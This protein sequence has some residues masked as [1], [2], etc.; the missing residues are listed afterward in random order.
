MQ[1][2]VRLKIL[3]FNLSWQHFIACDLY[4]VLCIISRLLPQFG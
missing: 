4:L 2:D 3:D 1:F